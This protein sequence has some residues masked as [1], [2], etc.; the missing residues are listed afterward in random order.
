MSER[1]FARV[2]SDCSTALLAGSEAHHLLHV[3]RAR[4]RD[5]V[6]V[7]DGSGCEWVAEVESLGR[8]EAKLRL[9]ECCHVDR[10]LKLRLV[11]GV[12]LPKGDRQTWLVEK[13]VE[14]GVAQLVPLATDR[15]VAQPLEKALDRLR[16][17]VIEAS[18]QCGRNRLMEI[19]PA[20]AWHDFLQPLP[21]GCI[22]WVAAPEA[23]TPA[24]DALASSPLRA[25]WRIAI[26]PEGGLTPDEVSLAKT[27]GWQPVS[28][29][30]RILRVE[31]AAL[32][33]AAIV[34]QQH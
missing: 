32:A 20:C 15:S 9:L 7:F 22:G 29:G 16:R 28:L 25:E 27:A 31:T 21:E 6:T 2:N 10:E 8:S 34:S 24:T 4:L 18:K 14:L 11:L 17:T 33:L 26:G 19:A 30:P 1:F 13:A 3:M 23:P 5:R 12:A